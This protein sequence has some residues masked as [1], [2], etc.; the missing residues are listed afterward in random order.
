MRRSA[1]TDPVRD[2]YVREMIGLK[3][4]ITEHKDPGI[5]GIT[6]VVM[7]E[8]RNTLLL[9][10]DGKRLRIPKK[11]SEMEFE[12]RKVGSRVWVPVSGD[13]L[14]FRPEDRTKKNEMRR[15][16]P[17]LGKDDTGGQDLQDISR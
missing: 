12:V 9:E 15:A 4:H 2:V 3:V 13:H 5:T 16:R 10:V 11:G 17:A 8:T 14:V 7:D 1:R 6:G